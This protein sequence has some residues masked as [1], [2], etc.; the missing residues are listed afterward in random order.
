MVACGLL[1]VSASFFYGIYVL[2]TGFNFA[3]FHPRHPSAKPMSFPMR[4]WAGILSL[5][6]GILILDW[7][8]EGAALR[9]VPPLT[10][11]Q[12][13]RTNSGLLA[14][15]FVI[16]GIAIWILIRPATMIRWVEESKQIEFN[17]REKQQATRMGRGILAVIIAL[18]VYLLGMALAT[19]PTVP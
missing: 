5:F 2:A 7:L 11:S 12:W 13:I 6:P 1:G 8:A 10:L 14:N 16:S 15:V 3:N 9:H 18:T 19:P 4:L 17:E